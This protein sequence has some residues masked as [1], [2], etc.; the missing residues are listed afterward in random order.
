[1][2]DKLLSEAALEIRTENFEANYGGGVIK[3]RI[4]TKGR[5][6]SGSARTIVAFKKGNNCYFVYGF[7]KSERENISASEVEAFKMVS[8]KLF[9]FS[10]TDINEQIKKDSLIEVHYE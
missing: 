9:A 4:A 3:K 8:K 1:M 5:G 6:K 7:E 2:S 10:D